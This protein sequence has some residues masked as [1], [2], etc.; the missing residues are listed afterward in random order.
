MAEYS[1]AE[2]VDTFLVEDKQTYIGGFLIML[3]TRL[4]SVWGN[5]EKGLRTGNK[6][7]GGGEDLFAHLYENKDKA[8]NFLNAMGGI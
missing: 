7:N 6:Q 5:L 3:D 1:N 8:M 4:Y 2:D